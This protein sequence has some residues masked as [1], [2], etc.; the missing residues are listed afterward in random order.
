MTRR[1]LWG[2]VV[3]G[4]VV[5]VI[6]TF[7]PWVELD[8]DGEFLSEPL[9]FSFQA[10][11]LSHWTGRVALAAGLLV[12]AIGIVGLA[13]GR[14]LAAVALLAAAVGLVASAYVVFNPG[15]VLARFEE[16][17]RFAAKLGFEERQGVEHF[18]EGWERFRRET[19]TLADEL[20]LS[21]EAGPRLGV[22]LSLAGEGVATLGSVLLL[23][24]G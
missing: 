11:G 13:T 12:V 14:R 7:L 5:A 22:Y 6:G 9:S 21:V 1:G 16:P 18:L 2:G 4:A 8:V 10:N 15:R 20:P 17:R 19:S 24:R 23:R 3:A